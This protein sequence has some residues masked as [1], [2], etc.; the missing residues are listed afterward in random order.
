M[1]HRKR[2]RKLNRSPSHRKALLRNLTSSLLTHGRIVTTEE[3][4]KET[5]PFV[6]KLITIAKKGIAQKEEN[7]AAYLHAY[8]RVLSKLQNREAVQKLFGEGKWREHEGIAA[9]Y[10]DRPGGYTRILKLSGSRMGSLVGQTGEKRVLEYTMSGVEPEPVERKLKLVGNRLGDN[11]S[12]V[13]FELVEA[14]EAEEEEAKSSK[15]KVKPSAEV[16][17]PEPEEKDAEEEAPA[18][19]AESDGSTDSAEAEPDDKPEEDRKTE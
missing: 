7:R 1:R 4:A 13:M 2:G 11:A 17:E 14:V 5:R 9:R 16:D 15:P 12:R 6:E 18:E 8:R 10:A 19:E 3:K